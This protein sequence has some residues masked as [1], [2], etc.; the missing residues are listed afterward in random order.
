MRRT[1]KHNK[2]KRNYNTTKKRI[3]GN[4]NK[5]MPLLPPSP[6]EE[7]VNTEAG[8]VQP[9]TYDNLKRRYQIKLLNNARRPK[10]TWFNRYILGKRTPPG[11]PLNSE[12]FPIKSAFN[13]NK[14]RGFVPES[15]P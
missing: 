13:I 3:R 2:N 15:K 7:T 1:H 9:N 4:N 5:V 10:I 12:G 6:R 8:P 11:V 14:N